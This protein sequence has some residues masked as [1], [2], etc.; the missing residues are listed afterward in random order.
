VPRILFIVRLHNGT[1]KIIDLAVAL[2]QIY[3]NVSSDGIL[4]TINHKNWNS[5]NLPKV[6]SVAQRDKIYEPNVFLTAKICIVDSF[7]I[8][9]N[10]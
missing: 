4:L 2:I 10:A 9:E 3:F 6:K 1:S 7:V 5:D 8:V